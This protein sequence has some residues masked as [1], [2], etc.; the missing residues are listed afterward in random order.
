MP[1]PRDNGEVPKAKLNRETLREAARLFLYLRP[2]RRLFITALAALLISSL[3]GL[4]F[5]WLAGGLVDSAMALRGFGK[6]GAP[7]TN[8]NTVALLLMA[9]LAL[10]AAFSFFQSI[11]FAKVGQRA[12]ADLR[13]DAYS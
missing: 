6:P 4:A 7:P 3:L 1:P 2:Y 8:M 12:L 13:K 11:S 9:A 10:Q 5:P